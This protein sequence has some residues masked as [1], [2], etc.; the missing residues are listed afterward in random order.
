M[1]APCASARLSST[2]GEVARFTVGESEG[3]SGPQMETTTREELQMSTAAEVMAAVKARDTEKVKSLLEADPSLARTKTDDG[4]LLLT[5]VYYGAREA[6][7]LIQALRDDLD[8]GEASTVG[9]VERVRALVDADPSLVNASGGDG[10]R[11]LHL[12]AYFGQT[13]V[14]ELLLDRGADA[15]AFSL[16]EHPNIPR[17]TALHAALAG[18]AWDVARLLISRGAGVDLADSHGL[19]PLHLAASNGS[20]E[21][22]RILLERGVEVN[23]RDKKG[24]TPLGHAV[25][26]GHAEVADLLRQAGGVE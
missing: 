22:T 7:K 25:Q 4:S 21:L 26:R 15:S 11:P 12:A 23:P 2:A 16:V 10:W 13:G 17:N 24:V 19:Q 1:A 18:R 9:D 8:I 3:S 14:A 6:A 20:V 5:A